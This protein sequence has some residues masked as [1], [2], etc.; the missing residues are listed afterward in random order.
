MAVVAF[1]CKIPFIYKL[2]QAMPF[3]SILNFFELHDKEVTHSG[4]IKP[5]FIEDSSK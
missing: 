5:H 3:M 4:N 2:L 1:V